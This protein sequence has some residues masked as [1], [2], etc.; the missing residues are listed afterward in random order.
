MWSGLA[1]GAKGTPL[2]C[3]G[4]SWHISC[5]GVQRFPF[6]YCHAPLQ[7]SRLNTQLPINCQ[8]TIMSSVTLPQRSDNDGPRP[9]LII[10]SAHDADIYNLAYLPDG[11]RIVTA[12]SDGIVKVWNV[13]SGEQEQTLMEHKYLMGNVDVSRDGTVTKIISTD[14]DGNIKAWDVESHEL[15]EEWTHPE[16]YP[17]VAISPDGRL[18]AV[19]GARTVA[20]CGVGGGQVNHSI[21]GDFKLEVVCNVRVPLKS[22]HLQTDVNNHCF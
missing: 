21:E 15:M 2:H 11:R 18:V 4:V 3:L 17:I 8:T 20:I 14:S 22:H 19:H 5:G 16:S 6:S 12:S 9:H 1:R 10:V 7:T 13:E